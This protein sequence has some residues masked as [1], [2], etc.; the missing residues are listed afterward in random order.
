MFLLVS[1]ALSTRR[2]CRKSTELIHSSRS[3][4][5][6]TSHAPNIIS[7]KV[8]TFKHSPTHKHHTKSISSTS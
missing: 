1:A 7:Y 2:T 6:D 3:Q 5:G 8:R 4:Y